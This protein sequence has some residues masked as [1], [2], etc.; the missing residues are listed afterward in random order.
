MW[1]WLL[2]ER[3]FSPG[4]W[5][6][7]ATG[8]STGAAWGIFWALAPVPLQSIFAILS[9]LMFRANIPI[10]LASCWLSF[11]GYQLIVWPLQWWLGNRIMA[12]FNADSGISVSMTRQAAELI[13]S[14][15]YAELRQLLGQQ[16]PGI[17][18]EL[19]LGCLLSCSMAYLLVWST[20]RLLFRLGHKKL[21]T[22]H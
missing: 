21:P 2:P 17:A 11:P 13:L 16:L 20:T 7:E 4:L 5:Q 6:W 12:W 19:M 18:G 1:R 22:E 15:D 9:A 14:G 8:V 3:I 10:A